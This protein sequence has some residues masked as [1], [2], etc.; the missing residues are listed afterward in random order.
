MPTNLKEELK[1]VALDRKEQII[2]L[3]AKYFDYEK[4]ENNLRNAALRGESKYGLKIDLCF[5]KL[6]EDYNDLEHT[7]DLILFDALN[8]ALNLLIV[9]FQNQGI[10][11]RVASDKHECGNGFCQMITFIWE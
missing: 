5:K 2:K 1:K 10:D 8:T 7:K 9:H 6:R 4:I 11:V 3:L